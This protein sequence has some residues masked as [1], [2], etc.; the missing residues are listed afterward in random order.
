M[1]A[2][3]TYTGKSFRP[4]GNPIELTSGAGTHVPSADGLW[5]RVTLTAAGG[6]GGEGNASGAGGGGQAGASKQFVVRLPIAGWAYVVPAGGAPG[7]DGGDV[8]F[9]TLRLPGGK[10][11]GSFAAVSGKGGESP[12]AA[13]DIPGVVYGGA[14]GS[15]ANYG[16]KPSSPAMPPGYSKVATASEV[17]LSGLVG[18]SPARGAPG[19]SSEYGPGG[20]QSASGAVGNNASGFGGGGGGGGQPVSG[21]RAGGSG[22]GG[23]I[24]IEPLGVW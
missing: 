14:G 9:G 18:A 24:Y 22:T 8:V 11:G 7:V 19:G 2:S 1:S 20:A 23:R 4:K 6:G 5:C 16:S 3:S 12:A 13:P 15:A 21:T 17:G 10:A